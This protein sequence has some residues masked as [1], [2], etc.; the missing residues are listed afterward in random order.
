MA[1]T[2]GSKHRQVSH[3][4]QNL[5]IAEDSAEPQVALQNLHISEELQQEVVN[6][7]PSMEEGPSNRSIA[8]P[9]GINNQNL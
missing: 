7:I 8:I 4:R 1:R 3:R 2:C 5:S 9:K 6:P